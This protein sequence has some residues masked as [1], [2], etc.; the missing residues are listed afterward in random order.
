MVIS[1]DEDK[2]LAQ[3]RMPTQRRS[4]SALWFTLNPP[5]IQF[6]LTIE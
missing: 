4:V 3:I 5:A 6:D 2:T 1:P